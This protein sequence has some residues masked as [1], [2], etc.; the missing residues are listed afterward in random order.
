MNVNRGGLVT[1][2]TFA[3]S[4]SGCSGPT[5]AF[6]GGGTGATG[7][8]YTAPLF[9]SR[10]ELT[11]IVG[12]SATLTIG[13]GGNVTLASALS[14]LAATSAVKF[15]RAGSTLFETGRVVH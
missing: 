14:G 12:P 2:Y 1:G 13:G 4:G 3:T 8:V 15:L 11:L 6:G 10:K 7:T 5:I 9:T